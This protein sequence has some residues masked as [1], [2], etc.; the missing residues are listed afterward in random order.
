MLQDV[1]LQNFRSYT[2][3]SFELSPKVN[4]IVGPNASGKTNLIEAIMLVSAGQSYRTQGSELIHTNEPWARIEAHTDLNTRIVKLELTQLEN[5]NKSFDINNHKYVRLSLDKTIPVVIFEPNQLLLI[6]GAPD[7]RR[8]FIDTIIGQTKPG[9]KQLKLNFRRTLSQRNNLLKKNI[10]DESQFFAW[11]I[12]LSQQAGQIIKE[13][14][15]LVES[16]NNK[17]TETYRGLSK[18][19]DN[20]EVIY[21]SKCDLDNYETSLLKKL[22]SSIDL[23]MARGFTTYGPHRDDI[24]IN[25]NNKQAQG[26]ASRGETRTLVLSLKI[27]EAQL[28]EKARNIKPLLLL[29]DV[30]SELDGARR[31]ALVGLINENYQTF[32][33]TTDAD[34]VLEHFMNNSKIIPLKK[35]AN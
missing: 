27:I 26:V 2:D 24:M 31:L 22:E 23:D 17:A 4:I 5:V 1:R 8:E 16:V 30:F 11:N 12:R 13:R 6:A 21:Q 34:I 28:I 19:K 25:I 20:I 29:D 15:E 7:S 9:F 18:S 32:I 10:Y 33:T 3:E 35:S 14:L